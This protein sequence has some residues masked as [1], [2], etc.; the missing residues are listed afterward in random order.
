MDSTGKLDCSDADLVL[1]AY[2]RS[3]EVALS[4]LRGSFVVVV[5]D[6][7]R[8][9]AIVARDPLG[10]HPLFYVETGSRVLFADAVQPLLDYPGVSRAL[11]R[12]ALADHLCFRWPDRQET[13]FAAVRR[14]PAGWKAVIS[15]GRLSLGR[16]WDPMPEE[17]P[18]QSLVEEETAGF[19]EVFD[20]SVDR[21][22]RNGPTGIFLSGGLDSISVAAIATDRARQ[23]GENAPLA[24]SL[25]FSYPECD[26]QE[27]QKAVARELG[28]R[29]HLI[30]FDEA[31]G[32][33]PLL[34]QAFE[35][36]TKIA[37][38]IV[39]A[40]LPAYLALARR[41]SRD[42]V[43]TILTGQGG[44]EWLGTAQ[45]LAADLIRSGSFIE[46]MQFFA[47]LQRSFQLP[48]LPLT[49]QT[50]WT[51]GLRPL[52]ALALHRLM[53]EARKAS[54]RKRL[55]A[56]DPSWV[57]PDQM[58]RAEQ[59]HRAEGALTNPDPPHGFY[60]REQRNSL[61]NPIASWEAEEQY[62][63]G[64]RIGVRFL[65]PFFDA[66]VVETLYR[67]P[68][69]VLNDGGRTKGLVRRTLAQRFPALGLGAQRKV[70]FTSFFQSVIRREA[71]ALADAA[72][73]F[74]SLSELSIVDSQGLRRYVSDGLKQGGLKVIDRI[75]HILNLESWV[76]SHLR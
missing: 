59:R 30:G 69:R 33:R 22:L 11:N 67:T 63:W 37:A 16:Y 19:E 54:R 6:R 52:A 24:L 1:H 58:L 57:A 61:D 3:G 65:H 75:F 45:Y 21:C 48:L 20:R 41:A 56:G 27:C 47:M 68:P 44:D 14:V 53:P 38:P 17:R 55:L 4:H 5:I 73:D 60:M 46:L 31:L 10:S 74:P 42:G 71:P 49:R 32:Q 64:K 26:E 36:N 43:Q 13:F 66:D 76:R 39:N 9:T 72:G 8:G 25:G 29:Q 28:L 23:I 50:F 15:G 62:E 2:E 34:E 18:V 70:P 35:L 7:R 40:C 51:S 12:V